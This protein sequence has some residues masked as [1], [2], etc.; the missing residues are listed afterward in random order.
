MP[1]SECGPAKESRHKAA[2]TVDVKFH[3]LYPALS[4]GG[5]HFARGNRAGCNRRARTTKIIPEGSVGNFAKLFR[6]QSGG[7]NR[8]R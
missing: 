8:T 7:R 5:L 3:P 4:Y 2:P 1:R 6:E